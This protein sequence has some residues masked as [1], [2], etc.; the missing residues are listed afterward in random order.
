LSNA[1]SNLLLTSDEGWQ[2]QIHG[3]LNPSIHH[4]AWYHLVGLITEEEYKGAIAGRPTA[5]PLV[6]SFSLVGAEIQCKP[7]MWSIASANVENMDQPLSLARRVFDEKLPHTP[8]QG[9]TLTFFFHHAAR[10]ER[11]PHARLSRCMKDAGI[12]LTPP[13]GAHTS[14]SYSCKDNDCHET[15]VV[16]PSQRKDGSIFLSYT[17][18]HPLRPGA[19]MK[20]KPAVEEFFIGPLLIEY[21]A[22]AQNQAKNLLHRVLDAL[23]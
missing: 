7:G 21:A 12:G 18:W 22:A 17:A 4:P 9:C 5:G 3:Y 11:G 19:G 16:E 6:A 15:V 23:Q 8:V 13:D 1:G 2:L 10:L 20:A 14:F